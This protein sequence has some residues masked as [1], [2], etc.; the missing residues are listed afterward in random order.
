M[1][2]PN[3][4]ISPYSFVNL[5]LNWKKAWAQ[6]SFI[7]QFLV[8]LSAL[9]VIGIL[10]GSF[11][12]YIQGKPGVNINDVFLSNITPRNMSLFIFLL[13]YS[14]IIFSVVQLVFDPALL[15]KLLM[16]YCVLLILRILTLYFVSLE[17]PSAIIPL[18]DPF[19]GYFFYG[20][21]VITKDLFFS[22][23]ISTMF[24]LFFI[25]PVKRI[26]YSI[27][28]LS[29]ITA[30]LILIQHVHY[31]IDVLAAP[32]FAWISLMLVKLIPAPEIK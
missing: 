4:K 32:V 13:I 8:A 15:L 7:M 10:I 2:T 21:N 31:T 16:A 22:G 9:L 29:L 1:K 14:V 11:F 27:G 20:K 17:A 3:S 30:F 26:K 12:S 6:N 18:E 23:H 24:L 28:M 19:I 25:N 5:K